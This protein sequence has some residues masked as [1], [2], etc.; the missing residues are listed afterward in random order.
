MKHFGKFTDKKLEFGDGLNVITGDNEA[1][2]STLHAFIRG[3]LFGIDKGRGRAGKADVYGH[4]LPWDTPGAYQGSLD[5]EHNGHNI[6][7]SRVFLQNA[8]SCTVTDLD[9]GE[10]YDWGEA[11]ITALIGEL[12]PN[13]FDN[14]V[15]CAQQQLK[16]KSDFGSYIR[17]YIANMADSRDSQ[18]DVTAALENLDEKAKTISREIKSANEESAREELDSLLEDE[19]D[20]GIIIADRDEAVEELKKLE[21]ELKK[22]EYGELEEPDDI[23]T[24]PE[25]WRNRENLKTRRDLLAEQYDKLQSLMDELNEIKKAEIE[26]KDYSTKV[27]EIKSRQQVCEEKLRKRK[28]SLT[29]AND[30]AE[31]LRSE[32][33]NATSGENDPE[34]VA[35]EAAQTAQKAEESRNALDSLKSIYDRSREKIRKMLMTGGIL[36]GVGLLSALLSSE[37]FKIGIILGVVAMLAGLVT[38]LFGCIG[39]KIAGKAEKEIKTAEE[40]YRD[41]VTKAG[42]LGEELHKI[43][44]GISIIT[45]QLQ[46]A[47]LKVKD[48]EAGCRET[49]VERNLIN[50]RLKELEEDIRQ[51]TSAVLERRSTVLEELEAYITY[52]DIAASGKI[53]ER[54]KISGEKGTDKENLTKIENE[55]RSTLRDTAETDDGKRS[56][57]IINYDTV[58]TIEIIDHARSDC[59]KAISEYDTEHKRLETAIA[60]KNKEL[61]RIEGTL[62]R[63]G[64]IGE[65]IDEASKKLEEIQ[66][67]KASLQLEL[68]AVKLAAATVREISDELKG[69][70]DRKINDLL[71]RACAQTTGG[72]Y[73]QARITYGCEPEVLGDTGFLEVKDL[74]T[75]TGEQIFLAFRLAMSEFLFGNEEIPMIFDE[76]FAYYDDERLRSA[77]EAISNLGS[78]QVFLFTCSKREKEILDELDIAYKCIS[79]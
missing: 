47:E 33:A 25:K 34:Q 48:E 23:G 79:L 55:V 60:E 5:L 36:T 3:M 20:E 72:K 38:L 54:N 78:R 31:K 24:D 4:Y 68:D 59:S 26:T 13:A 73:T 62:L 1:G 74:S 64:D 67:E 14:T 50:E 12:T 65:R 53:D 52:S 75:G 10:I 51:R 43:R 32:L 29:E 41:E 44:E 37:R 56:K 7:I 9:S 21:L 69:S 39:S 42:Q 16:S 15:S 57:D 76:I 6:R 8:K 27:D 35:K 45:G 19:K 17:S 49:E 22:L 77:L 58:E 66:A 11:G 46:Q 61:A 30:T 18:V 28:I 70:F 63:Y 71:S 40:N 2:K